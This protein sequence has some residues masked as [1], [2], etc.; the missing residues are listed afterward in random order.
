ML[1]K[2]SVAGD[3]SYSSQSTVPH[4][5]SCDSKTSVAESGTCVEQRVFCRK[6][7]GDDDI[8]TST[9][10]YQARLQP[11]DTVNRDLSINLSVCLSVE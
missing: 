4:A 11:T 5:R 1:P 10:V 2:L 3:L 8:H 7:S 6:M 9:D